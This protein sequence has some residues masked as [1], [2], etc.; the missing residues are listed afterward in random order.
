MLVVAYALAGSMKIDITKDA[1]GNGKNGKPVY[2]R[3]IWPSAKEVQSFVD[4]YVTAKAFK[5]RYAD[6]FAGD[7]FW[8]SIKT[9]SSLTLS[10][11]RTSRP[12]CATRPISTAWAPRR[13]SIS[14]IAGARPLGEFG[15]LDHHRP[16]LARRFDPQGQ[17]GRHLSD[18]R[19]RGAPRTSTNTARAAAITRW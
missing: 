14:N 12:M 6:V 3:D 1:L 7:R 11:G 4:K 18:G 5:K 8:R 2:L 15:D 10:V 19:G 13:G 17:P 9:K 16:H